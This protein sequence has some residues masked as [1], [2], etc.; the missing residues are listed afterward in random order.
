MIARMKIPLRLPGPANASP[1]SQEVPRRSRPEGAIAACGEVLGCY[2]R[3]MSGMVLRNRRPWHEA[4]L[5][6]VVLA[7]AF[8]NFGHQSAVLAAGGRIVV[9]ATSIC[10]DPGAIPAAGDHF[11]CHGCKADAAALPPA[12]E[13]AEPVV[14]AAVAVEYTEPGA[15]ARPLVER[16]A[17]N[18]RGPPLI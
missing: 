6:L 10:G 13:A 11:A 2:K 16:F 3:A 9:T 8:L 5:A 18:S 15:I 1:V 17:G 4:L 7:L 12:P 14:F